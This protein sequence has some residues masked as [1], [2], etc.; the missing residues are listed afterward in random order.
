MKNLVEKIRQARAGNDSVMLELIE[1]WS[2]LINKFT[3]LLKYDEDCRSDLILKLISLLKREINLDK[4]NEVS[5]GTIINYVK[6]AMTHHYITLS[7]AKSRI[8]SHEVLYG[9]ELFEDSLSKDVAETFDITD[10]LLT[11]HLKSVLTEKEFL[12]VKLMIL[13]GLTAEIISKKLGVSKQAVNQCKKRALKKLKVEM[14]RLNN[15]R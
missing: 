15:I 3:R 14:E 11:D 1:M 8:Q 4:M 12:C 9:E 2:P 13:D 10:S 5:D 6:I 7:T